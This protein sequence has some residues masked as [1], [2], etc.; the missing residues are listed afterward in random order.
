MYRYVITGCVGDCCPLTRFQQ[1]LRGAHCI[2]GRVG[3]GG[4][5]NDLEKRKISCLA[6]DSKIRPTRPL[7]SRYIYIY[8]YIYICVCVCVCICV[9][10]EKDGKRALKK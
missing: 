7:A 5:L 10:R 6:R 4:R 2:G 1:C 3:P 8:I 9:E